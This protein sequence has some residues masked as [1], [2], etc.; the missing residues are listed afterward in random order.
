MY[1][2]Y[3]DDSVLLYDSTLEDLRIGSG[4]VNLDADTAGSFV[5]SVFPDHPFY[6]DFVELKTVIT[7]YKDNR[8]VFR[9]R[10]LS[11]TTDYWNTKTLTCEGELTFLQDSVVRPYTRSSTA[12]AMLSRHSS[13]AG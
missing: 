10:V 4:V 2:I 3:A 7:V 11:D 1:K 8:I 5:F 13:R 9:G 12:A 6:N